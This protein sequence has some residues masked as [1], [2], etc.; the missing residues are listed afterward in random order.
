MAGA[1]P[2]PQRCSPRLTVVQSRLRST[3]TRRSRRTPPETKESFKRGRGAF[4][5]VSQA[6]R[7]HHPPPALLDPPSPTQLQPTPRVVTPEGGGAG[8]CSKSPHGLMATMRKKQD[9]ASMLCLESRTCYGSSGNNAASWS[10]RHQQRSRCCHFPVFAQL[11]R[12]MRDGGG[13]RR[14]SSSQTNGELFHFGCRFC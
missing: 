5:H 6:G 2:P 1:S 8:L 14:P 7:P 11:F 3:A 12:F 9:D 10:V 13:R 4:D